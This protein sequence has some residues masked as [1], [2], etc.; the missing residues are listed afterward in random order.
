MVFLCIVYVSM[1]IFALPGTSN[2]SLMAGALLGTTRA[3]ILV[4]G[5]YAAV[6]QQSLHG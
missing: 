2:L 5:V 6:P 4:S 1:Q 3:F